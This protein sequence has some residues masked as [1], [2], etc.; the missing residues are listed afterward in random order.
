MDQM[1]SIQD[2]LNDFK[3]NVINEAKKNLGKKNTSGTLQNSI[4]AKVKESKNSIEINFEMANYGIFQ[5][6]GVK[7]VE[8]GKSLS[9][10]R[11]TRRG[12]AGSLKG[13]PPPSAF[14]KWVVQKG[15]FSSQIRG[16]KGRFIKRKT[17]TFLIARSVF[18]DGIK[19]SMFFTK[20]FEKHFKRLPP[21]LLEK[22]GLDL[23]NLYSQIT[24]NSFKEFNK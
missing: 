15:G 18:K 21:E 17:L 19:P 8:S 16:K 4:R 14:D 13:M 5:D 9:G 22:F 11:Y 20:P 7:G 10:Y 1:D 24:D 6:R 23:A 2:V 3:N 12:G